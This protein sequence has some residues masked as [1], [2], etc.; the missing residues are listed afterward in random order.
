MISTQTS[1]IL[2]FIYSISPV[3]WRLNVCPVHN[4]HDTFAIQ[5]NELSF[6]LILVWDKSETVSS[7]VSLPLEVVGLIASFCS[8]IFEEDPL[9]FTIRS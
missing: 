2:N 9:A 3:I 5:D 1:C 6:S 8:C 4:N 7:F